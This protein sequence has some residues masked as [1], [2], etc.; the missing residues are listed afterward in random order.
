MVKAEQTVGNVQLPGWEAPTA[1]VS[2]APATTC[3]G[4]AIDGVD[5]KGDPALIE[6]VS[7]WVL[8]RRQT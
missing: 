1:R 2:V 4:F 3:A 6:E 7:R 8:Q 5:I